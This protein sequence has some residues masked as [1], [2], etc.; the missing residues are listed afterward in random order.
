MRREG[1]GDPDKI[2]DAAGLAL[3]GREAANGLAGAGSGETGLA[4]R[5]GRA[6]SGEEGSG[7][8]SRDAA[9][10]SVGGPVLPDSETTWGRPRRR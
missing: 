9:L 4:G 8:L 2:K 1:A 5:Q 3:S 7:R 6:R 10:K